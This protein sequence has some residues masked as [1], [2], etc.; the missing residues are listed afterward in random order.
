MD[1][2]PEEHPYTAYLH[3]QEVGQWFFRR[4]CD[5]IRKPDCTDINIDES[6]SP[7]LGRLF[8]TLWRQLLSGEDASAPILG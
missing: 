1:L 5:I 6:F 3:R 4:A 8:V 2:R 7:G